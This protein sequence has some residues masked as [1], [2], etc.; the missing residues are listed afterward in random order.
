MDYNS[1]LVKVSLNIEYQ[2]IND[3]LE[4]KEEFDLLSQNNDDPI[5]M[6][7]KT[8]RAKGKII[9]ENEPLFQLIIELHRKID[10]LSAIIN[11]KTKSYL[12]LNSNSI[13]DSIG[14]SLFLFKDNVLDIGCKYYARINIAIFPQRIMPLYFIAK[15]L[16]IAH[17]Y[18]MHNSDIIDYDNY[19][20]SRERAMIRE[21]KIIK[22]KGN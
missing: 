16:N 17:I 15:D 5:G 3:D 18:L 21:S 22:Q 2:K 6:W 7:L 20:A 13:L 19:I 4:F 9:D 1:R 14:H 12:K 10:K 8:M 11:N